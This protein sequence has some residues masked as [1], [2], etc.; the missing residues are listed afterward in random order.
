MAEYGYEVWFDGQALMQ[1]SNA[2][3][4]FE[5]EIDAE[6]EAKDAISQKIDEWKSDSSWDGE[7]INDFE[8]KIIE[9]I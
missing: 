4:W 6:D 7:T 2:D 8:I 1:S 3:I 9:R 5:S